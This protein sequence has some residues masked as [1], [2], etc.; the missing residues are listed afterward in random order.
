LKELIAGDLSGATPLKEVAAACGLSV[1]HFSRAFNKSTG[2]APHAWLL[3]ARVD[4]A[5]R[6]LSYVRR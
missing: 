5:N 6:A 2:V 1:S 4:S 3:Q